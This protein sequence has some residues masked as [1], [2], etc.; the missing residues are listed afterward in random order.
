[1]LVKTKER[2]ETFFKDI[3][4]GQVFREGNNEDIFMK[5]DFEDD[6]V[7]CPRCDKDIHISDEKGITYAVELKSGLV[8]EFAP[9]SIVEVV[10]GAFIED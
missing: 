6:Y 4:V 8:Y 9:C 3:T 10:Q 5:I 2:K 7:F 1:M